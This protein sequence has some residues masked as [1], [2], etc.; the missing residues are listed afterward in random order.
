METESGLPLVS[1][2]IPTYNGAR[3]LNEA[4][5]SVKKQTY[6]HLEIV[7]S[8]DSST[9]ETLDLV[10]EFK[11][12]CH[13]PLFVFNHEQGGIGSNWNYCV[14]KARGEFIKFL[15]QDDVLEPTCIEELM[16][17]MGSSKSIGLVYC[18]RN[19]LFTE[20]TPQLK[21]FIETYGDLTTYWDA[22]DVKEGVL[23]GLVYLKDA[24]LL[25]SPKNKIG[26][27]T[28][29]LLAKTVFETVGYF[30]ET[31][32]QTLD[33]EF[34]YRVMTRYQIGY[35]DRE[36]VGFRLHETQASA[37]NKKREIPDKALLYKRYYKHLLVYLHPRNKW[38][39]LK[40]YHPILKPLVRLKESFNVR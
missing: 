33:C 37:L 1:I 22:V 28:A 36:L 20:E 24:Q 34:W 31:L 10:E 13:I 27:P 39:L 14:T 6:R 2:C 8:D 40:L 18:R 16:G 7:I 17:L 30:D 3:Y 5:E 4:L 25:N 12:Q 21:A 11:K 29:V 19:F 26:E 9:D 38:K 23:D 15:F 35:L 32:E